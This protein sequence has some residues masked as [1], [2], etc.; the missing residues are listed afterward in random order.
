M[1]CGLC[2]YH[3]HGVAHADFLGILDETRHTM[4][5]AGNS[6]GIHELRHREYKVEDLRDEEKQNS[7]R[8]VTEDA[9]YSEGPATTSNL[10]VREDR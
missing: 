1:P 6:S 2:S 9:R 10:S 7:F 5:R 4:T 8:V 3:E